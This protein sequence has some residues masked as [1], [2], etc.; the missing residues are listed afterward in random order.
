MHVSYSQNNAVLDLFLDEEFE[1]AT[2]KKNFFEVM[3][4]EEMWTWLKGPL[5][6]GAYPDEWYNG[7]AF[8]DDELGCVVCDRAWRGVGAWPCCTG[9]DPVHGGATPRPGTHSCTYG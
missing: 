7:R 5:Y 4:M 9:S 8:T 2:Y 1:D 3:T 6:N